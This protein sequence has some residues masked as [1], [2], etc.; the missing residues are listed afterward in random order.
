MKN[1][2]SKIKMYSLCAV[3]A[4]F[5][6]VCSW[7]AIPVVSGGVVMTFQTFAVAFVGY[8]LGMSGITS[9]SV[10]II[11]GLVGVPVFSGF[12]GGIG[13]LMGPT[14]GFL[15]GF[16]VLNILCAVGKRFNR[17]I[18][19]I[20]FGVI[21]LLICHACGVL[22]FSVV[23]GVEF[24]AAFMLSSLPYIIKDIISVVFADMLAIKIKRLYNKSL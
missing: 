11:L 14:G 24:G 19:R 23:S 15:Y 5:T 6:A 10:Y 7:I 2:D 18:I 12:S 13:V 22:H 17:Q 1:E 20:L 16:S 8:L 9:F 21:G 4:V 3:L